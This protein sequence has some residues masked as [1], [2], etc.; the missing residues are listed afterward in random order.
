MP[1]SVEYSVRDADDARSSA[2]ETQVT[3]LVAKRVGFPEQD[4][5][6]ACFVGWL[7]TRILS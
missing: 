5:T 7:Y 4:V 3:G 1:T 6:I 2:L